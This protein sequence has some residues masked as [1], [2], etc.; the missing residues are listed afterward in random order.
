M[1]AVNEE[2][3]MKK[4]WLWRNGPYEFWAFDNPYPVGADGDP[5]TLGEP[6]GYALLKPST[7]GR[8]DRTDEYAMAQMKA[9]R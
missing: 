2:E 7:N 1:P 3:E 5:L 8:P 4:L 9:V 6:V